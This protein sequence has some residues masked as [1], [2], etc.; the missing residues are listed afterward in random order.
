MYLNSPFP[1]PPSWIVTLPTA[2]ARL[3]TPEEREIGGR[4]LDRRVTELM[5]LESSTP[6]LGDPDISLCR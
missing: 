5:S 1:S 2:A 4:V 3:C 6:S